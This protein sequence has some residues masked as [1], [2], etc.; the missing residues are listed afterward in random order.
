[1]KFCLP[2][3]FGQDGDA[4]LPLQ[5]AGVHDP[6]D[7]LL[8]FPVYPNDKSEITGIGY[9]PWHYRYVGRE[10]AL[11]IRDSGLCMEEYLL[12]R[13]DEAVLPAMLHQP[14]LFGGLLLLFGQGLIGLGHDVQR[15]A[16]PMR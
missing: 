4:P 2:F 13:E 3:V 12:L 14:L 7:D 6:V 15:Q 16:Q 9:E 8:V 5:V 11:D 1:M 10:V